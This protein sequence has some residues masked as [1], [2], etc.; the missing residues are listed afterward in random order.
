MGFTIDV[1]EQQRRVT[2]VLREVVTLDVLCGYVDE[3][4]QRGYWQWPTVIDTS[5]A[6]GLDLDSNG[7]TSFATHV[8]AYPA[9]GPVVMVAIT[10]GAKA[11]G[12][13]LI[14]ASR[15]AFPG[16]SEHRRIV[17]SMEAAHA[18]LDSQPQAPE[19]REEML[20]FSEP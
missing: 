17:D 13:S 5:A 18:W 14:A 10:R 12:A 7:P 11:I 2:V 1:D 15:A 20:G 4:V 9:R 8:A 6:L 16:H 3:L 19:P